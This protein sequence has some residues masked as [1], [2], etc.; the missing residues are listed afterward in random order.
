MFSYKAVE[1]IKEFEG[2]SKRPYLCPAGYWTIGYGRVLTPEEIAI[3]DKLITTEE[4]ETI[5]VIKKLFLDY[6]I[7]SPFV[8]RSLHYLSWDAIMSL[9]YNIGTKRFL[10]ST[11]LRKINYNQLEEAGD[12]FLRWIYAGGKVLPGLVKR[13]KKERE[14]FLEGVK[15]LMQ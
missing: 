15:C 1:L 5:Y 10:A 4:A 6:R 12:Q 14:I 7:I 11:L 3:K 9:V 13:R 2:F 8:R